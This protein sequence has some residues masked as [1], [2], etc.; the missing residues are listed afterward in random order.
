MK[1]ESSRNDSLNHICVFFPNV[2]RS[3]DKM[4][5]YYEQTLTFSHGL[6]VH[7]AAVASEPRHRTCSDLEHVDTSGFEAAD[8]CGIGLTLYYG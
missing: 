8:D 3:L 6:E 1:F 7:L 2:N 5:H 4:C